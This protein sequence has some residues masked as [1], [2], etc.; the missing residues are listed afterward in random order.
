MQL[1]VLNVSRSQASN[2]LHVIPEIEIWCAATLML[3]RYGDKALKQSDLRLDE[4]TSSRPPAITMARTHLAAD[5]RRRRPARE[6]QPAR[7]ATLL[8]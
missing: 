6:Q 2:R 4:L 8:H 5:L 1:S 7:T 3:K